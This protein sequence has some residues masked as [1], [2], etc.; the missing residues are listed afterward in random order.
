M[1]VT[2]SHTYSM[3]HIWWFFLRRF[4]VYVYSDVVRFFLGWNL[5][6]LSCACGVQES[7]PIL[8]VQDYMITGGIVTVIAQIETVT[9]GYFLLLMFSWASANCTFST[10]RINKHAHTLTYTL[11]DIHSHTTHTDTQTSHTHRHTHTHTH[12]G[13]CALAHTPLPY[14]HAHTHPH[15]RIHARARTHA[16]THQHTH[17][18]INIHT[19]MLSHTHSLSSSRFPSLS[20]SH[21]TAYIRLETRTHTLTFTRTHAHTFAGRM[22]QNN[23]SESPP[24]LIHNFPI[25]ISHSWT[26]KPLHQGISL[27]HAGDVNIYIYIN[28]CIYM[29]IYT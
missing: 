5:I 10:H 6:Q 23:E 7:V 11:V 20:L 12:T 27:H 17:K 4:L 8:N 14:T 25:S 2:F 21:T 18:V 15:T 1:L 24:L 26:N 19:R 16:Q 29:Y 13:T 28:M 9:F 3:G 22:C